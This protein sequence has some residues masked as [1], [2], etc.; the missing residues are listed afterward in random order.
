MA[1]IHLKKLVELLLTAILTMSFLQ[2]EMT[3]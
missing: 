1:A 2:Q 3:Y